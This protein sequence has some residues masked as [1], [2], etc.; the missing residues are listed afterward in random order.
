MP[1]EP[2]SANARRA[3]RSAAIVLVALLVAMI[4]AGVGTIAVSWYYLARMA[5][6]HAATRSQPVPS[7]T[8]RTRVRAPSDDVPIA[9]GA[10]PGVARDALGPASRAE[11]WR[12][13]E[14]DPEDP[15]W[16]MPPGIDRTRVD[17]Q[18]LFEPARRLAQLLEPRAELTNT[19]PFSAHMPVRG[20]TVD[21]TQPGFLL[22]TFSYDYRDAT[23]PPGMDRVAGAIL[24]RVEYGT[25]TASRSFSMG[26]PSA[27][28]ADP[29]CPVVRAWQTA[30]SSG[31][32]DNAV[33]SLLYYDGA[34]FFRGGA[35]WSFRVDGHD[36][37]R[38]E[39]DAQTCSLVK[40]WAQ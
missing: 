27:P 10:T 28:L 14:T 25:L 24:V 40:S 5:R 34:P 39:I 13:L 15:R 29:T 17:P 32:P 2:V 9:S 20:G 7:S 22:I 33:A 6:R 21:L 23:R 19:A 37:L 3:N 12:Y 11:W 36:E 1:P 26:P 38:R 31:V 18:T 16:T 4:L 30:V 8:V 35:V